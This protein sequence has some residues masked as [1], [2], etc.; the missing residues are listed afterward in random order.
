VIVIAGS[1]ICHPER[2]EGP[3]VRLPDGGVYKE[4]DP[5]VA[6]LPQDDKKYF[7]GL[8]ALF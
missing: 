5:S 3:E 7:G 6:L 2:G 8:T 1:L 4:V